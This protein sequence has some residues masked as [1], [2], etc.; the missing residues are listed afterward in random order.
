MIAALIVNAFSL[1]IRGILDG[2]QRKASV[3]SL[4]VSCTA[5]LLIGAL[6]IGA[7]TK[8]H[9]KTFIGITIIGVAVCLILMNTVFKKKD[10]ETSDDDD[11]T[12]E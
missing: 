1:L 7:G 4:I 12:N 6:F 8:D 3:K 5:L 9:S 11:L 10:A 2:F